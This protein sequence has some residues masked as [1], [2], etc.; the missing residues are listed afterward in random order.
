MLDYQQVDT[1]VLS[2]FSQKRICVRSTWSVFYNAKRHSTKTVSTLQRADVPFCRGDALGDVSKEKRYK[3][4][5]RFVDNSQAQRGRQ[6][7]VSK[8]RKR[9]SKPIVSR[10]LQNLVRQIA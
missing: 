3:V 6:C 5:L 10:V 2:T 4:L 9:Y 1:R 8:Q 7:F